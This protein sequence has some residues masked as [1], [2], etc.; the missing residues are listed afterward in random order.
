MPLH[1]HCLPHISC[2]WVCSIPRHVP[3]SYFSNSYI[4]RKD[5][6]SMH[7]SK[8]ST[9][10]RRF[11]LSIM[12]ETIRPR[13]SLPFCPV[14]EFNYQSA[15]QES[16]I[17]K[18][19]P[20]LVLPMNPNNTRITWIWIGFAVFLNRLRMSTCAKYWETTLKDAKGRARWWRWS[21]LSGREGYICTKVEEG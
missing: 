8:A 5:A 9:I 6:F 12:N 1:F 4:Q 13:F 11:G 7:C 19:T 15:S 3:L 20:L 14:I 17:L 21:Q 10:K 18:L 16:H 2:A